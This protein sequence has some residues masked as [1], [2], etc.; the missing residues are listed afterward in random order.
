VSSWEK[1]TDVRPWSPGPREGDIPF[2]GAS[3]CAILKD[4]LETGSGGAG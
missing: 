4:I 1:M 2:L 3:M